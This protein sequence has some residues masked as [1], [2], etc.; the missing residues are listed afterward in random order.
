MSKTAKKTGDVSRSAVL[1]GAYGA[2]NLGDEAMLRSLTV[3]LSD[4]MPDVRL[5]II[6]RSPD[7]DDTVGSFK[8][9]EIV[10]ALK[11]ADALIFGGGSLLQ[12]V[13]H[14]R[15]LYYYLG[16]MRLAKALGCRVIFC[17]CGVGPVADA[18]DLKRLSAALN[19]YADLICLRDELSLEYLL[20]LGVSEE[21]LRLTAD[22][23]FYLEPC[24][25]DEAA[26]FLENNGV[27]P[28]EKN[29]CFCVR[30]LRNELWQDA[31]IKAAESLSR[32][33]YAPVF[34]AVNEEDMPLTRRIA[35]DFA[36]LPVFTE[37]ELMMG[38]LGTMLCTVSLRLHALV[39]A[40]AAGSACVGIG[41]DPKTEGFIKYAGCGENLSTEG[42]SADSIVKAVLTAHAA[43]GERIAELKN[44]QRRNISEAVKIIEGKY[45]QW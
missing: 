37:P 22:P 31:V 6:T 13:T 26:R 2:G 10:R 42:L 21:K 5:T 27:R 43:S 44:S 14:R 36:V 18:R 29:I 41:D 23:A 38:V 39:F 28:D 35:G 15:S 7:G 19:K 8:P 33:G 25:H 16:V 45:E 20:R 12:T 11:N 30:G 17:G 34:A 3:Q 24:P 9:R 40:A 1:C 4:A 32:L